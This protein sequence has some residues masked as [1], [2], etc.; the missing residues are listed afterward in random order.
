MGKFGTSLGKTMTDALRQIGSCQGV[1]V[2]IDVSQSTGENIIKKSNKVSLPVGISEDFMDMLANVID[3]YDQ[4]L[5]N[6]K[7]R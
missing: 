4:T 6:L 3:E 2:L 7:D 1:S 5:K